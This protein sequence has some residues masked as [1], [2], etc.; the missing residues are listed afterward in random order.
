MNGISIDGDRHSW[1]E[2]SREREREREGKIEIDRQELWDFIEVG[3][4]TLKEKGRDK[5]TE[6]GRYFG[7]E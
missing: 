5:D 6:R 2:I 3:A 4:E 1:S 7:R